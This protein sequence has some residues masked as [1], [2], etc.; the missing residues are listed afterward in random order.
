MLKNI[1]VPVDGTPVAEAAL[2]FAEVL[3]RR[4]GA[5]LILIRTAHAAAA[6]LNSSEGQSRAVEEA[7]QYLASVSE[8]LAAHGFTVETAI[9]YGTP[10]EWIPTEVELREVDLI[11]MA[12][13]D[14]TGP[15]RWI[16]GSVA[17][18]VVNHAT[19]PVLLIR[20]ADLGHPSGQA[21]RAPG[22]CCTRLEQP[23]PTLIVPL[24]GSEFA[25]TVLPIAQ[26][27]ATILGARIVLVGVVPDPTRV[28][29]GEGAGL[30]YNGEDPLLL[31]SETLSYLA[32]VANRMNPM[33]TT[34]T[35]VRVGDAA[36]E[37]AR[38]AEDRG[39]AVVI[40]A[41]HGRTGLMRTILGSV[42][43][44]VLHQSTTPVIL[45]RPPQLRTSEVGAGNMLAAT[46]AVAG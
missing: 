43:G 3:A 15:K 25:E 34:E 10:A 13:H 32:S 16:R 26:G 7:E 38:V 29:P 20:A 19:V 28:I 36:A 18:A 45:R 5:K 39:A 30:V 9:P 33:P 27:F 1:L 14:R 42:A 37:I 4:T 12:T 23:R 22:K 46:A 44:D 2:P 35:I 31:Q 6:T 40:M 17:E 41:T 11:V 8:S 24:D 21:K